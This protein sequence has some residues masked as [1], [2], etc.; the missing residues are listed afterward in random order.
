MNSNRVLVDGILVKP[1]IGCGF[2]CIKSKCGASP[3]KDPPTPTC[4]SLIWYEKDKRYY[5]NLCL[6]PGE[7]GNSYKKNLYINAGCCC[8]LNSWRNDVKKRTELV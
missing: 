3:E 2:C 1:C 5:C 8:N 7:E 6:T 4:P